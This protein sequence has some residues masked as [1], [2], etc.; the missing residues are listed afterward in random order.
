MARHM[1]LRTVAAAL[2]S[3]LLAGTDATAEDQIVG[4]ASVIDGDTIEIHSVRIRLHGID[5]PESRQLC[6]AADGKQWR[7]GHKAS[8]ALADKISRAPVACHRTDVDRYGRTVA[9]CF[10]G[11][12]DINAWLVTEG[13]AVAY[14][15]YSNDYV[16]NEEQAKA[17]TKGIWSSRFVMPW[18][19][20]QAQRVADPIPKDQSPRENC[21]IKGN[22]SADGEHI[23]HVPSGHW[24][25]RTKIDESVGERWFCSEKE[26]IAGGWRRSQQ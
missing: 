16:P 19:W 6:L 18:D 24:Y 1:I 25:A 4:V 2:L 9:V 12:E 7:C 13:W 14:R 10:K 8:L 3:V 21:N 22:I 20:R 15:R 17:A 5:A 26:A 23:Y 11:A